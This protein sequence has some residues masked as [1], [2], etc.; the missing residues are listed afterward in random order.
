VEERKWSHH[1]KISATTPS[2]GDVVRQ[3]EAHDMTALG[4]R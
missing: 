3:L 1:E 2:I 4:E